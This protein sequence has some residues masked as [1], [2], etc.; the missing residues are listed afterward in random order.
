M[1]RFGSGSPSPEQL[2]P[3]ICESADKA[4][5]WNVGNA[6]SRSH[7]SS[8]GQDRLAQLCSGQREYGVLC[9]SPALG[10]LA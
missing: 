1:V 2:D 6:S 9:K 7:W 10:D 8:E 5:D 4:G 3:A